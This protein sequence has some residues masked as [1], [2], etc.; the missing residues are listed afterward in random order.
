MSDQVRY[1]CLKF[2]FWCVGIIKTKHLKTCKNGNIFHIIDQIKGH[3]HLWMEGPF[4]LKS[5]NKIRYPPPSSRIL[6]FEHWSIIFIALLYSGTLAPDSTRVQSCVC[7]L[8]WTNRKSM[9]ATSIFLSI[10]LSNQRYESF[11]RRYYQ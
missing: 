8:F 10:S 9:A 6:I 3:C 2:Q 5:K 1:Q 7:C 4:T 11:N